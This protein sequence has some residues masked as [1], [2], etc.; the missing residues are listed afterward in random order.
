MNQ[1][2]N[3]IVVLHRRL[4]IFPDRTIGEIIFCN[5]KLYSCENPVHGHGDA[6]TV[7]E[8]KQKGNSAIPYGEY[9]VSWEF[10]PKYQRKMLGLEN[11]PGFQGIRIH[12]GNTARDTKG[13]I[14]LGK[15]C[16]NDFSAVY[17]S[18]AAV[19]E[20]ESILVPLIESGKNVAWRII[21]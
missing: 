8:W 14:L 15:S 3:K 11:V 10:S 21:A 16:A 20:L 19:K 9:E 1:N 2:E 6:S 4:T 7:N 5:R 17:E 13:C 18:R 12:S